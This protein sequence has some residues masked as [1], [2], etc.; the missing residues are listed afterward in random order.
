MSDDILFQELFDERSPKPD[1]WKSFS[2]KPIPEIDELVKGQATGKSDQ[3]VKSLESDDWITALADG[4]QPVQKSPLL[5]DEFFSKCYLDKDFVNDLLKSPAA[6]AVQNAD[7]G[8]AQKLAKMAK[9]DRK[10]SGIV[11]RFKNQLSSLVTMPDGYWQT[12]ID[13]GTEYIADAVANA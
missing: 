4:A 12:L 8:K 13:H 2:P 3:L 10:V 1:A 9:H 11:E 5:N 6:A 7:H